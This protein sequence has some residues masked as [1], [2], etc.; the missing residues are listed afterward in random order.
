MLKL[1][2]QNVSILPLYH[3]TRRIDPFWCGGNGTVWHK[4]PQTKNLRY[5]PR[6][7]ELYQ[8]FLNKISLSDCLEIVNL[9]TTQTIHYMKDPILCHYL[10]QLIYF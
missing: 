5:S 2:S 9:H 3:Y 4:K 7:I 1:L 8:F 6:F 10:L